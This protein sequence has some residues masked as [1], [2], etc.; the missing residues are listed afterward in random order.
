MLAPRTLRAMRMQ[1]EDIQAILRTPCESTI[2]LPQT[3]ARCPPGS[4]IYPCAICFSHAYSAYPLSAATSSSI[5]TRSGTKRAGF[6]SFAKTS[7]V[8]LHRRNLISSRASASSSV[9]DLTISYA[10]LLS[11]LPIS[12]LHRKLHP[13]TDQKSFLLSPTCL[14]SR[15]LFSLDSLQ[16]SSKRK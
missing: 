7:S 14:E 10:G 12:S 3:P 5:D 6:R 1:T 15:G 8:G 9:S 13:D 16:L 2:I 11:L 4:G